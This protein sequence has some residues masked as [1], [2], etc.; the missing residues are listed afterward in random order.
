VHR[1]RLRRRDDPCLA[2]VAAE[3]LARGGEARA[4]PGAGRAHRDHAREPP[5]GRDAA[6]GEDGHLDGGKDGL[7]QRER[8]H[9]AGVAA[10]IR[11]LRDYEVGSG[12]R[13]TACGL[14]ARD[15]HEQARA[16]VEHTLGVRRHVTRGDPDRDWLGLERGVEDLRVLGE[17]PR[18]HSDAYAGPPGGGRVAPQVLGARARARG[19]HPERPGGGDCLRQRRPGH[20]A[21]RRLDDRVA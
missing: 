8:P 10:G 15:L 20:A 18:E 14:G 3:G 13:G 9:G 2:L 21:H 1:V 17:A 11:A 6:G 19:K 16:Y 4:D 5:S 7:E 12:V